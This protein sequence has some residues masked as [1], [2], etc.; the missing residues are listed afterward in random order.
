MI[1]ADT[2]DRLEFRID[3]EGEIIGIDWAEGA[4]APLLRAVDNV[5]YLVGVRLSGDL[6][7]Q[8]IV[9]G[10][11]TGS[12]VCEATCV[13]QAG[14]CTMVMGHG[15]GQILCVLTSGPLMPPPPAAAYLG[16]WRV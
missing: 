14:C 5:A 2:A 3:P 4:M 12:F 9:K 6:M 1:T 15:G 10:H 16:E 11:A 13:P 8:C 7:H